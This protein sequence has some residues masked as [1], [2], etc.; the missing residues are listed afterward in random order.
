MYFVFQV[1]F[2]LA[3]IGATASSLVHWPKILGPLRWVVYQLVVT[4][5]SESAGFYSIWVL[6][7]VAFPVYHFLNPI[8]Y[9]FYALFFY[10]LTSNVFT[11]R[12]IA[13]TGV[14]LILF[15]IANTLW[16]Q[17]LEKDN[18]NAY[19]A[20]AALMVAYSLLYYHELYLREDFS[21]PIVKVPAFW[22][23]TG[24]FFLYAGS[25]FVIGFTRIIVVLDPEIAPDLNIINLF[26]NILL[27]A[28][29]FYGFRCTTRVRI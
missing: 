19:L 25:F 11:K 4:S 16:L 15:S 9:I 7:K 21:V 26:L 29:I 2:L 27:Y 8:E 6:K 13:I 24:L 3:M 23:V 28:L 14:L 18:S 10:E 12:F 5:L 20:G 1:L 17:P 22:I